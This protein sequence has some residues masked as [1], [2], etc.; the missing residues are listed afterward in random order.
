MEKDDELFQLAERFV[1]LANRSLD[2]HSPDMVSNAL[3]YAAA[4][5]NAFSLAAQSE[6]LEDLRSDKEEA[7]RH[8]IGQ[9]KRLLLE[10]LESY[11]FEY[12]NIWPN[13]KPK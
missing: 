8:Y 2:V 10:N 3:L 12:Q 13:K 9:Y 7:S 1:E 6:C 11:E 5:F 4:G